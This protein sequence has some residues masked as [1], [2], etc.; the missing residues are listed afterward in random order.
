MANDHV[1]TR[2]LQAQYQSRRYGRQVEVPSLLLAG[3]WL[4][5]AGFEIG[6]HVTITVEEGRL[7][8][9]PVAAVDPSEL[10]T[11]EVFDV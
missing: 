1:R 5:E 11:L 4:E 2:K 8:I 3:L 7:V 10:Q 9:E 6:E